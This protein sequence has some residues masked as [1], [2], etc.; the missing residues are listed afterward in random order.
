M[1]TER[2]DIGHIES[3]AKY[4]VYPHPDIPV[5]LLETPRFE[6]RR[7][8]M[9]SY[10]GGVAGINYAKSFPVIPT[11]LSVPIDLLEIPGFEARMKLSCY[12]GC[13]SGKMYRR[14]FCTP[15]DIPDSFKTPGYEG[16]WAIAKEY[17]RYPHA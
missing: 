10:G 9:D 16:I 5:D 4:S 2:Y 6:A 14:T 8:V 12:P 15:K 7:N 3:G 1:E 17:R 11:Y 13:P